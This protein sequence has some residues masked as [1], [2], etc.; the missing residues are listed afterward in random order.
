MIA[1]EAVAQ[2]QL[3]A[4]RLV[5]ELSRDLGLTTRARPEPPMPEGAREEELPTQSGCFLTTFTS[6]EALLKGV[7][8]IR[9]CIRMTKS[10]S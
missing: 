7:S 3:A 9:R 1:T 5:D 6:M 8:E 10:C 4:D 2:E